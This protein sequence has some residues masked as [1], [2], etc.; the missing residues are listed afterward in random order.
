M[1]WMERLSSRMARTASTAVKE[2]V[3]GAAYDILPTLIGIGGMIFGVMLYKNRE[4]KASQA[5]RIPGYSTITITTNNYYFG[6]SFGKFGEE[7]EG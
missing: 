4:D 7:E 3:Q 5:T 6:D 2:E 1:K